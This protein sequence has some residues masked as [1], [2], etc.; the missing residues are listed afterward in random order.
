MGTS[1]IYRVSDQMRMN[2]MLDSVRQ[3]NL[4]LGKV[5]EQ[6]ATGDRVPVP[7]SDPAAANNIMSLQRVL[8]Q[9]GQIEENLQD[10][11]MTFNLT[12]SSLG[13]ASD[14]L[15]EAQ[16]IA[17]S[18]IG[19]LVKPEEKQ[20]AAQLV[21][22][23]AQQMLSIANYKV[24]D[25]YIFGGTANT[26][27]PFTEYAG[28]IRYVGADQATMGLLGGATMTAV[29]LTGD[30]VFGA[31][32]CEVAGYQDLTPAVAADTRLSD[33]R[34]ASGE[35]I[36]SGSIIIDDGT[37]HLIV[38]LAG[39]DKLG[40]VI[41]KI[42]TAGGGTV[43]AM[44]GAD[45]NLRI[46]S[47]APGADVT[48]T[49]LGSSRAAHDLGIYQPTGQGN[50]FEGDAVDPL[51]T[52]TTDLTALNGGAGIDLTNGLAITNGGN[53]ATLDFSD[54]TTVGDLLNRINTAG[55]G[56][57]GRINEAG[58]G[59]DIVNMLSGAELRI[60]ENG[61]TTAEDLGVRSL[62]GET[63]LSAL[64]DGVGVRTIADATDIQI[65][66]RDGST[67]EVDLSS[68]D[69][70]SDAIAL[71]N[72]AASGVGTAVTAAL[73][74]VGNGV[75]LTDATGGS[76]DLQVL[77]VNASMAASDL[78]ISQTVSA[79]TLTGDDINP[80]QP[81]G[82]FAHLTQLANALLDNDAA[83]ITRTAERLK[84]DFDHVVSMRARV[85]GL[86]RELENRT[87]RIVDQRTATTGMISQ[88]KDTDYAE[89]IT[90]FQALQTALQANLTSGAKI[91][92]LSLL[93]FLR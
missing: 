6:L 37:N 68:A 25:V 47:M 1:G 58:T 69:T 7:S 86:T 40:D 72:T 57:L 49:E 60:G 88:N 67:F 35:G 65:T 85:G 19:T 31:M 41:D 73:A 61:G 28:G 30:E 39:S 83:T 10:A 29:G 52:A 56:V 93:D 21:N 15:L 16:S 13:N 9:Q 75:E 84:E 77:G 76:G 62:R 54:D 91:L 24:G 89:A 26:E 64:N 81:D 5:Q 8:A 18:N 2:T 44:L 74:A 34:G 90:R 46:F 20:A 79:A 3:T 80:V 82:V 33:L 59:I 22:E 45:N 36:R 27:A 92:S 53:S 23:V 32:S 12:D 51:L 38:D 14:L 42:N 43:T 70:L 4:S 66:A 55:L 87:D 78:G 48:V 63:T 50:W 71:I 11:L 17:S